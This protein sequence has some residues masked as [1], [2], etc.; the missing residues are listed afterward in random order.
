MTINN[1]L[2]D[3]DHITSLYRGQ[4][5]RSNMI[6]RNFHMC[7]DKVKVNLF[8]S[9]CTSLYCIS[10]SLNCRKESL[11]KLRVCYNNSLRYL[12][13]IGRYSSISEQFVNLRIPSFEEL[14][15]KITVNLYLRIKGSENSLIKSVFN[16]AYFRA[17]LTF[18]R[19]SD[20][21]FC[22]S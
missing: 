5:M 22:N 19:W 20:T 12:M 4:C 8:K 7:N 15:R 17:S 18:R 14:V 1:D 16:S 9:F 11:R 3:D 6:I 2:K 21:I 10:L 13:G